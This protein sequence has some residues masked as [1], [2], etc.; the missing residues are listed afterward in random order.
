MSSRRTPPSASAILSE[1]DRIQISSPSAS[2]SSSSASASASATASRQFMEERQRARDEIKRRQL[3][4]LERQKRELEEQQAKIMMEKSE[5]DEYVERIKYCY[6]TIDRM[7]Q[8]VKDEKYIIMGHDPTGA[9]IRGTSKDTIHTDFNLTTATNIIYY[10]THSL[11]TTDVCSRARIPKIKMAYGS[12]QYCQTNGISTSVGYHGR[13]YNPSTL[14]SFFTAIKFFSPPTSGQTQY[15]WDGKTISRIKDSISSSIYGWIQKNAV[16]SSPKSHVGTGCCST[17]RGY[18]T[19]YSFRNVSFT[20]QE[21]QTF[22]SHQ[23]S[24][25]GIDAS[26]YSKITPTRQLYL[27]YLMDEHET[28]RP[29]PEFRK[30]PEHKYVVCQKLMEMLEDMTEK[31]YIMGKMEISELEFIE[32]SI[33]EMQE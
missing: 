6:K 8:T 10:Y 30:T 4:E 12:Y 27:Q 26:G 15:Q 16:I 20:Y 11:A 24:Q 19:G 29:H 17:T 1:I 25:S 2:A 18:Q 28:M 22:C 32:K 33:M 7:M 23:G 5:V 13:E 31:Y 9:V 21:G 14:L 3:E